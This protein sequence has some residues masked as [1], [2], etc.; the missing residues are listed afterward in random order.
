[1]LNVLKSGS[2]RARTWI[3][4]AVCAV[5]LTCGTAAAAQDRRGAAGINTAALDALAEQSHARGVLNGTLLVARSGKVVYQRALGVADGARSRPLTMRD[6]FDIGS[7]AKEFSA[8]ALIMLARDGALRLDDP[9]SRFVPGLPAWGDQVRVRHLLDYSSGLPG[10]RPEA[11]GDALLADLRALPALQFAPGTGY[12]YSNNNI[13]LR[14]SVIEAAARTRFADFAER[15][16][17]RPCGLRDAIIDPAPTAPHVARAFDNAYLEDPASAAFPGFWIRVSALDLYRW[18]ECLRSGRIVPV[19]TLAQHVN[20]DSRKD[21]AL[22]RLIVENGTVRRHR[23]QGS[24][25]NFEA[26]FEADWDSRTTVVVLTNNKNF[27]VGDLT[28]AAFDIVEGKAYT[29]PKRSLYLALRDQMAE[30]GFSAGMEYYRGLKQSDPDGFDRSAEE[31]DLNRTAYDLLK[32]GK[33]A[34][35][36]LLFRHVADAYPGSANAWDS[37]GEALEGEGQRQDALASYEKALAL[38][39]A[40]KSSRDA[41]ARLSAR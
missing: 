25:S 21:G 15:R 3:S 11:S 26:W 10:L 23:H 8:V 32:K 29:V 34:D 39:P 7:I 38:D 35:A 33:R 6:R 37:L 5:F 13:V 40:L 19:E 9:V 16:L 28:R 20:T 27:R 22:G 18:S 24:S 36:L 4:A 2:R 1:L 17:L 30:R 12:L 14:R 41:V 31:G